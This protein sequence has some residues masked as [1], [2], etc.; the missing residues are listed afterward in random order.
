MKL[1]TITT[2][3]RAFAFARH[4]FWISLIATG[5]S[6]VGQQSPFEPPAPPVIVANLGDEAK[7]LNIAE[8]IKGDA[9]D[10]A[11]GKGETVYVV[12]FWAT[13]CPPCL[14]SIP[15]LTELQKKFKDKGVVVIGISGEE[16]KVVKRFV[17]KMGDKMGYSVAIDEDKKTNSNYMRA[18]RQSGIPHAFVVDKEGRVA[19]HGHPMTGLDE[20][21][22]KIVAGEFDPAKEAE[23]RLAMERL[24]EK[25]RGYWQLVLA[26]KGGEAT[27]ALG[28][29]LLEKGTEIGDATYLNNLS[30]GIMTEE[31]VQY[32]NRDFALALAKAAVKASDG[33]AGYIL[34]TYARALFEDGQLTEAIQMQK[35]AMK[36]ARDR[37]ERQ[38]MEAHLEEFRN[39]VQ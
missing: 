5:S 16:P 23:D 4:A 37:E 14:T 34:D 31:D 39:G 20:A 25:T 12:E 10:I 3:A 27:D 13:W 17:N 32:R 1:K 33:E 36:F 19:W 8:W 2:T 7:P 11:K 28:S 15:H 30:W 35:K 18:Y 6:L 24:V 21:L 38:L 9:V 22:T 26:G 29:E